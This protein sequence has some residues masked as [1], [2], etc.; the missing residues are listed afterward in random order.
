MLMM[1]SLNALANGETVELRQGDTLR[2]S[3]SFSYKVAEEAT[4]PIWASLY[5]RTLGMINRAE[6]AQTKGTTSLDASLSWTSCE[7]SID[8]AIGD[9]SAGV[10]G[11]ILEVPGA[12]DEAQ[13][14]IDDAVSVLGT[15]GIL[16]MLPMLLMVLV[17]GMVMSV[18]EGGERRSL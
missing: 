6:R 14:A 13:Y 10:Y 2:V 1:T 3:Y 12:G 18:M 17:M 16:D 7:G 5:S 4:I 15:P 8:I 11:L 9:V